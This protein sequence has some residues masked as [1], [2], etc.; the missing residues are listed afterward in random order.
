MHDLL[1]LG[2]VCLLEGRKP[3][4]F[5]LSKKKGQSSNLLVIASH[6]ETVDDTGGHMNLT[7]VHSIMRRETCDQHSAEKNIKFHINNQS[8][9]QSQAT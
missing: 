2:D 8:F 6:C 7:G 1:V 5:Y 3:V 9:S 4:G